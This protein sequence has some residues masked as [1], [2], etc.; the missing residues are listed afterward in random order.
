M[1]LCVCHCLMSLSMSARDV[2]LPMCHCST[3]LLRCVPLRA[4]CRISAVRGEADGWSLLLL[5]E[6][7]TGTDPTEGAALGQ[8]LLKTLVRG[9]TSSSGW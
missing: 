7:G 5:D 1:V 2:M 8:A 6:L 9:K 4:V 3:L